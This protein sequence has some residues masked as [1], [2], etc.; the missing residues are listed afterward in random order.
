MRESDGGSEWRKASGTKRI[1]AGASSVA[2]F[3][4]VKLVYEME[5]MVVTRNKKLRVGT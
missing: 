3:G 4:R 5:L 1:A 2:C